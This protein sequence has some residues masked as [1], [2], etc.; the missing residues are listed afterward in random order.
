MYNSWE[1]VLR[2]LCIF[3]EWYF[4]FHVKEDFIAPVHQQINI[5][6][7]RGRMGMYQAW[8]K[9]GSAHRVTPGC[10]VKEQVKYRENI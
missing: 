8:V 5:P 1:H 6:V 9:N 7:Q 4:Q 10:T 3:Q 2:T